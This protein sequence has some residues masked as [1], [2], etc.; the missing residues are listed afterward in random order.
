MIAL[1]PAAALTSPVRYASQARAN[2]GCAL[3]VGPK[4]SLASLSSCIHR[5]GETPQVYMHAAAHDHVKA[6]LLFPYCC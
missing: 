2:I 6:N 4:S 3:I 5:L 1:T